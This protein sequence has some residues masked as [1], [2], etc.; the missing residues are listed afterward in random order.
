MPPS[1]SASPT[2]PTCPTSAP[3]TSTASPRSPSGQ[4]KGKILYANQW[5]AVS[6]DV[7]KVAAGKTIDRVLV[8][9]D[10]VG[11][12]TKD[13]RFGGWI[14]DV[15]VQADPAA[16]DGSDLTNY[17]DVRRGTNASGG[18][19]RGNNLPISAVPNGF[20]F[21][22][23]VTNATSQSWEYYYQSA[24]QRG[25]PPCAARPCDLAR[26]EPVDG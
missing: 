20:T 19:S 16:I 15:A 4:G 2:A 24:Q 5:N 11:G 17:V 18:F 21:F 12:A 8:G 3:T 6:L 10:N 23:P 22:T 9:Y 1:T 7:G 13:T 25:E 26:A 14:D